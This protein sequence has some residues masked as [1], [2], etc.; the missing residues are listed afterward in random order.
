MI[1]VVLP[2][3][4]EEDSIS[5]SVQ[6]I[7]EIL[8][9][10]G[11]EHEIIIVNDGSTDKSLK[12]L[13]KLEDV[14]VVNHV[15]NLGYGFALKTGIKKAKFDT[16]IIS[17]IDGSYPEKHMAELLDIFFESKNDNQPGLDMVVGARKGKE[18]DGSTFK[19]IFRKLLKFLVEW[20]T[21]R[22]IV[23]INSGQR[24]F[25]KK[26]IVN[27]LPHLCNTFSFTTSLTL[28]YMLTAKFVKY[29]DIEYHVRIG[30][31]HVKIFRDSL[32]TLQY[33]TEAI[34]FYNPL[35]LILL[36]FSFFII[37]SAIFLVFYFLKNSFL[38]LFLF[39][40]TILSSVITIFFGFML[41]QTRQNNIK[42][43]E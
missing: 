10:Y 36:I 27:F 19:F 13:N 20:T 26:T 35:K 3:Y 14:H 31:S 25:S 18:Y 2:C 5:K 43:K 34:I 9:K 1:S 17:D 21:G 24:V 42:N 29:H 41:E 7:K 11:K 28:A 30:K 16:I 6:A 4:N 39:G 40:L 12:I 22:K 33:I 23:D 32:R 8:K 15:H 37:L 38:F